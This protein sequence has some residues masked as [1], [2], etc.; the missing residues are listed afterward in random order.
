MSVPLSGKTIVLGV[1]GS[2]A[3]FKAPLIVTRLVGQGAT[4][5]VIMTENATRFVTPLTFETLSGNE[6][7]VGMFPDA[8]KGVASLEEAASGSERLKHVHLA[9]ATDLAIIAP[10]TANIIGKMANG[11]A[12]DF[13]STELVAMT[14][15]VIVAPAM[16]VRMMESDA[17]RANVETLKARGVIFAEAE[18]G[19]L[20]SGAVGKG[21]LADTESIVGTALGLLLPKQDLAGRRILV[22]AGPTREPVDPVRFIGNRSSGKMGYALA[23]RALRRGADVVLVSGPSSLNP[24]DGA[25]YV[26]V[27]TTEEMLHAVMKSFMDADLLIMA[28]APADYRPARPSEVK[29]KKTTEELTLELVRTEDILSQVVSARREGQGVVGFAL[30]TSAEVEEG[31]RKLIDKDLDIVVVNN[32]LIEGAGFDTDTNVAVILTR[33]GRENELA[34]MPKADLADV[35]LTEA[36]SELGWDRRR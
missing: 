16:N 20:A 11:V 35:I 27:E 36:I 6:V 22:S 28:A 10:A 1:T 12:D 19:R 26:S 5:I 14:C 17:V 15:P 31:R 9:E 23:E 2:I 29:I 24:P 34:R 8:K 32:P 21:R 33:S 3:A 25:E 7:I 30:E 4:V 18:V 13:L